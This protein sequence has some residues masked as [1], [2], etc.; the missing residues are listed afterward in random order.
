MIYYRDMSFCNSS[1]ECFNEECKI[2]LSNNEYIKARLWWNG[3]N[4]DVESW[5]E[6]MISFSN[7]KDT[8]YCPGFKGEEDVIGK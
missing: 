1:K 5:E 3:D 6:P 4:R 2:R 7:F 8:K